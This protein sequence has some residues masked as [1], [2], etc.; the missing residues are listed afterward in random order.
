MYTQ[1]SKGDVIYNSFPNF[2][3]YKN[4][5][6]KYKYRKQREDDKMRY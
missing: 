4:F 2:I 1:E 6:F 5:M 3:F